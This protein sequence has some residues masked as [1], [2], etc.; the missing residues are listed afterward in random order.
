MGSQG[1]KSVLAENKTNIRS[2]EREMRRVA[3]GSGLTQEEENSIIISAYEHVLFN[4]IV[5]GSIVRD[6]ATPLHTLG[7]VPPTGGSLIVVKAS[8]DPCSTCGQ[9]IEGC[10]GCNLFTSPADENKEGEGEE[11]ERKRSNY[12]GV[13]QRPSGRWAAEIHHPKKRARVWLG[14]FDTAE[15]AA[16]AYDKKAFEFRG[17]HAKLNFPN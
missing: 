7:D 3:L 1:R 15:E 6:L 12:R 11:E 10:L 9:G 14:T 2:E 13:R 5:D 16:R 17:N 4:E 8:E